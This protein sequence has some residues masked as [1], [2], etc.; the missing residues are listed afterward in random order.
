MKINGLSIVIPAL[1]E[2][3]NLSKLIPKIY[4][5][6]K[7]K[8]FE[9]IVVDDNSK[10]GTENYIREFKKSKKKVNLKCLVRKN[11]RSDLSKSCVKGFEKSKYNYILVMDGDGQHDPK[12]INKLYKIIISQEYDVVVGVRDLFSSKQNKLSFLRINMSRIITLI[13]NFLFGF[14]TSDPMSGFFIF[15]KNIYNSNKRLLFKKGYKILFDLITVNQ[16]LKIYDLKINFLIRKSGFSKLNFKI[17]RI[18]INHIFF[19]ILL[20]QE[21]KKT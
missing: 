21:I 18:L 4:K 1:Q 14:K 6:V 10:D 5:L 12:Y 19:K 3:K 9:V 13:V 8:N 2:Q 7:V 17:V 16:K 20:K 15:K 11:L